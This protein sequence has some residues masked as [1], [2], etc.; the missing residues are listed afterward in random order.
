M[1]LFMV[2]REAGYF[3]AGRQAGRAKCFT[4][5]G[6]R[7]EFRGIPQLNGTQ[8][9]QQTRGEKAST[10]CYS[11]R[12]VDMHCRFCLFPSSRL[13]ASCLLCGRLPHIHANTRDRRWR[14][15]RYVAEGHP[16]QHL[17]LS[18]PVLKKR[19][20]R[21]ERSGT[22]GRLSSKTGTCVIISGPLEAALFGALLVSLP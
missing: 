18:P 1:V 5:L 4:L 6:F 16:T 9:T 12:K 7:P 3:R 2:P 14:I 10:S 13:P 19:A 15:W 8:K 21:S 22:W 20:K 11:T 17:L